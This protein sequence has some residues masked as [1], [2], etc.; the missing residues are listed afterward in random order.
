[1]NKPNTLWKVVSILYIIFETISAVVIILGFIGAGALIGAVAGNVEAGVGIAALLSIF[2]L[3]SVALGIAA[4]V[5]GLK[6]N[7]NAGKIFAIILV[8]LAVI[9]LIN[10]VVQGE[11]VVSAI[12]DLILPILY[13]LGVN[14]QIKDNGS[15]E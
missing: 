4:G 5:I 7:V 13:A 14:K 10:S 11:G 15:A 1:M 6:A 12:I 9:V 8:A 3:V 2:G